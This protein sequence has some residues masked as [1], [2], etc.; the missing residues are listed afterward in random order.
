MERSKTRNIVMVNYSYIFLILF[1]A[2]G[3]TPIAEAGGGWPQPKGKG[4]FKLS[5]WWVSANMHFTDTGL[6]DPNVTTGLYNTNFYGEYGW[7]DRITTILNVPLLSRNVFNNVVSATTGEI[8]SPGD[9]IN[10]L[11][12]SELTFKYGIINND[13]VALSGSLML[14]LPFGEKAGGAE[15]NLQT[16]DGEFNQMIRVDAGKSLAGSEN[17]SIYGNIYAGFNN[18]NNGFS[19]EI[20]YGV[21]LGLGVIEQKLWLTGKFDAIES[22][23]NEEAGAVDGSFFANNSEVKAITA[24]VSYFLTK[25]FGISASYGTAISGRIIYAAPSYSFGVFIKT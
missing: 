5:E 21:E 17:Y 8:I 18:R 23:N 7:T 20:R 15:K 25:K 12:D 24:E 1:F 22:R 4:Y 10:T 9:E 19:D 3:V 14:G 16:G 6:K 2:I 13:I 11:G